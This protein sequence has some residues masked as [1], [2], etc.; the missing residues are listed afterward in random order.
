MSIKLLSICSVLIVVLTGCTGAGRSLTKAERKTDAAEREVKEDTR[1]FVKGSL[2]AQKEA[3]ATAAPENPPEHTEAQRVGIKYG[4]LGVRGVGLPVQSINIPGEIRGDKA[5]LAEAIRL[6]KSSD[7]HM[8]LRNELAESELERLRR[9][10]ALGEKAEKERNQNIVKRVWRWSI[11]TFGIGGLVAICIFFPIVIPILGRILA[12]V[13]SK[14]PV[15]AGFIGLIGTKVADGLI[16]G[17]QKTN[18]DKTVTVE[19]K[20]KLRSNLE[21]K[22]DLG[23]SALIDARREVVADKLR[24][25]E[26]ES[27]RL[28]ALEES[29]SLELDVE[30]V[31]AEPEPA[32]EPIGGKAATVALGKDIQISG[33]VD[34]TKIKK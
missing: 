26:A 5:A 16:A 24:R 30:P 27:A 1:K 33:E 4:E 9:L 13:V 21:A 17:V 32:D 11:A 19:A 7:L 22:K 23:D 31:D 25:Q 20:K 3:Q 12:W 8:S 14:I 29:A 28:K 15:L 2:D 10:A 34:L 18:T 6:E